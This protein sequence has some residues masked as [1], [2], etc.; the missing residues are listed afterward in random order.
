MA[1]AGQRRVAFHAMADG[2]EIEAAL[3]RVGE[4]RLAHGLVGA[5]WRGAG[6]GRLVDRGLNRVGDRRNRTHIG[7][8]GVDIARRE[9]LVISGR[10]DRGERHAVR[11]HALLQR[12]LELRGSPPADAGFPVWGYIRAPDR[13][14]RL[15]ED[16]RPARQAPGIV[17]HAA[18]PA[19]RVAIA[20]GENAIDQIVTALHRG[21]G[22]H[23]G[24]VTGKRRQGND[25]VSKMHAVSSPLATNRRLQSLSG[26]HKATRR[27]DKPMVASPIG[28]ARG[29]KKRG[30]KGPFRKSRACAGIRR[31]PLPRLSSPAPGRSRGLWRRR[32]GRRTRSPRGPRCRRSGSPP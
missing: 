29:R 30:R 8:H 17:E 9:H 18:R 27:G 19:R 20:A 26:H 31:P 4:V 14:G 21:L 11:S 10:H 6:D 24:H 5:G 13:E 7:D 3:D 2:D 15:V 22:T 32:R 25:H 12:A 23:R 16:L 28:P 1:A